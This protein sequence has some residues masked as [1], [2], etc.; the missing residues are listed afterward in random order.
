MRWAFQ[1]ARGMDVPRVGKLEASK[2]D[3]YYDEVIGI[4]LEINKD[5]WLGPKTK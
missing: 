4:E 1:T 5:R 2:K 3:T